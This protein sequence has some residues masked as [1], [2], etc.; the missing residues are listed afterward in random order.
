M[1]P[2][3]GIG[4]QVGRVCELLEALARIPQLRQQRGHAPYALEPT[5]P[6][7]Q[8]P[9]LPL[10]VAQFGRSFGMRRLC[11]L[12]GTWCD[13]ALL[14]FTLCPA[15]SIRGIGETTTSTPVTDQ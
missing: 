10:D 3:F 6:F 5:A 13:G 4:R 9:D 7:D 8:S 14:A 11:L 15:P 12:P 2:A 1:E